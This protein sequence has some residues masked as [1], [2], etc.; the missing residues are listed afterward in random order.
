M[1]ACV[2]RIAPVWGK[3]W[4]PLCY[5]KKKN[6]CRWY[7]TQ[8]PRRRWLSARWWIIDKAADSRASRDGEESRGVWWRI[9]SIRSLRARFFVFDVW[10]TKQTSPLWFTRFTG[11]RVSVCVFVQCACVCKRRGKLPNSHLR[12][13]N[14]RFVCSAQPY[15]VCS[16]STATTT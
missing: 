16:L 15:C 9:L 10:E 13:N 1:R 11:A 6:V 2:H 4:R 3:R 7:W 8:T 14:E 12:I 5:K